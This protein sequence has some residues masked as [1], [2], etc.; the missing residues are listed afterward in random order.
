MVERLM[1]LTHHWYLCSRPDW[2]LI[3]ECDRGSQ[4]AL[5]YIDTFAPSPHLIVFSSI[6]YNCVHLCAEE[7]WSIKRC[8]KQSISY[9]FIKMQ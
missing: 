5:L 2:A 4:T 8:I 1:F 9:L 7:K 3:F 6:S